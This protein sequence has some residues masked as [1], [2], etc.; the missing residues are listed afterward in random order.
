MKSYTELEIERIEK[1]RERGLLFEREADEM[2]D[3]VIHWSNMQRE[4]DK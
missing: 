3:E 2:M 4:Y 1:A